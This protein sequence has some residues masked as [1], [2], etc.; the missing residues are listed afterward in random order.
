M[1]LKTYLW[2]GAIL[3]VVSSVVTANILIIQNR[4][5][6]AEVLRVQT[7]NMQLMSENLHNVKLDLSFKEFKQSMTRKVDSILKVAEIASKAVK[8]VTITNNYY[9]DSSK[10]I[11]RP[12][13]VI[14]NNDI[15][16]PF[17][18]TKD[19]FSIAGYMKVKDDRP[20]L[21][22]QKREFKNEVTIVGYEKRPHKFL[23]FKW[24]K[25]ETFIE[26]SSD[27]GK[28]DVRQINI[29]NK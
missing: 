16:Y 7:N 15:T 12:E 27:C 23:F 4:K 13:P 29:V 24:G 21:V 11:I 20:E 2:I 8:T 9:I 10:T 25:K 5:L 22:I 17:I 19:C 6:K 14:S 18:D 26:S 3:F 28:T 1:K